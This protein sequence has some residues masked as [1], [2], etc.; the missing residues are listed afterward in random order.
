MLD[1]PALLAVATVVQEGSF[2]RA[3]RVLNVTPSAVSQRVKLLEERLGTVLVVRGQPCTATP[4]GAWLCRHIEQVGMLEHGLLA[5]LPGLGGAASGPVLVHVA[6]NADSLGTWFIAA[7]A[8]FTRETGHL[9]DIAV[10]D[11]DH[12]ADWLRRGEVLAAVTGIAQPVQGCK[13][14]ALGALRYRATASP[15]F[16]A[17]YFAGGV[18]AE[19]FASA[20]A[21]KFNEKDMLQSDW[22]VR[23]FGREIFHPSHRLP[24]TQ[25]F[26][27]AALLGMGW[28]LNP[29]QLVAGHLASGRLVEL[30]PD[31]PFDV[32]LFWQV[33]GAAGELL[34]GL[35]RAV[36][37][38]NPPARQGWDRA[39]R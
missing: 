18:T 39:G 10:D 8:R 12:T 29:E 32:P 35:T 16:V 34:K 38:A 22:L 17:R 3:A 31:T 5:R 20:P 28:G 4:S 6:A 15:D 13:S 25:G 14:I 11:Q 9:I 2:E 37:E 30:V 23:V 1:Y 19:A 7:A 36:V 26:V 27:E 21:L 33:N 24:S